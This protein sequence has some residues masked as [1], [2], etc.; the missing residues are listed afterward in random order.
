MTVIGLDVGYSNLKIAVGEAVG[1][2]R[3]IVRP[4]G[5]APLDR[6]GERIGAARLQDAVV[7][8]VDG[9]RW[10]AADRAGTLRGL[11]ALPARGLCRHPGL[12]G[13]GEGGPGARRPSGGGP[14]GHRAAGRPGAGPPAAGGAAP[15]ACRTPRHRAGN[16]RGRR[17]AHRAAA[18]RGLRRSAVVGSGRGD[19]GAH[20]GRHRAGAR[21]RLLL[22]RLGGDRG[23]GAAPG[24]LGDQ[25]GGDVGAAGTRG[26][27]ASPSST[28]AVRSRSPWRPRCARGGSTSWCSGSGCR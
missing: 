6:L 8:E 15:L 20:R 17:G 28:A 27:L 9:Q 14:A 18:G 12:S 25:P 5:A 22:L 13:A 1:S 2:P 3:M 11:A 4:A 26:R 23:R 7:V 21:C 16:G 19:A 10:A 24:C